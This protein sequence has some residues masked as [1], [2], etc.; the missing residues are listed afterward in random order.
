MKELT[1]SII[2]EKVE[3]VLTGPDKNMDGIF[4]IL[5][6]AQKGDAVIR[7]WID[8]T[9]VK[10]A[11]QKGVSCII[12]Q[13]PKGSAVKTAE[14]LELPFIVTEKIELANAFAI[15]WALETFAKNSLRVVVTGTN[16]KSTTTHMIYHI[17][18]EAGYS[19]Y[20]NTDS[21]SEFN[22]LIDPMVAKQIAEFDAPIE[23][24]V[25]EVSEVQGWLGDIMK[26]HAY[27]M[28]SAINPDVVIVTNV[29]LDHIG[30]VNSIE[31]TF[32]ETSGAVKGIKENGTLILNYEDPLVLKMK[33]LTSNYGKV[34]FFGDNADIKFESTGITYKDNILIKI[35]DLP[36]K[37]RHFVQNTMA[38]AGAA[39]A[40]NIDLETIKNSISSYKA[41]KRR[42][43]ILHNDPCIIDDFAHN[44]DGILAT[45]QN[46]ALIGNGTLFV[47]S[48][49]RGSRG[50]SINQA[51][52]E[53][54]AKGLQNIPYKL[55]ITSSTDVVDHLNTVT[56]NEKK[57]FIDAL[58]K[59][60]IT[61]IFNEKL[62]D[63]LK[64]VLKL[65]H[66]KNTILLIG[67]QGMDPASELLNKIL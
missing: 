54:I 7:H 51:N 29:A 64:N 6:D 17:L 53:A 55:I 65:S 58:E 44:P 33:D 16:G 21:E 34:L 43:T 35:D 62:Y 24:A 45:I 37:S 48:A 61:Y 28:T 15:N 31:E 46:A 3:G 8:E 47:V 10:I 67:A 66:N 39:I 23:A 52:A 13:N 30:L 59:E 26:D 1:T 11:A 41:L 50:E 40:L 60:K 9:G 42:F 19:T 63:A 22:T 18:K 56:D 5:K 4:N 32:N 12:T 2:A 36:F 14:E 38:A 25:I 49:I 27:L 20:T 57:V